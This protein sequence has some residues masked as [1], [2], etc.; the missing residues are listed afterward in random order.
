MTDTNK[1]HTA[2]QT[3]TQKYNVALSHAHKHNIH[4]LEYKH[5]HTLRVKDIHRHMQYDFS[6]HSK[7]SETPT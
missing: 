1:I 2:I 5:T 4:T 6:N 3:H 7:H